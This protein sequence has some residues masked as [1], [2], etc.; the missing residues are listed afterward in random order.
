MFFSFTINKICLYIFHGLSPSPM[1][2]MKCRPH[3]CGEVHE[4]DFIHRSF[5]KNVEPRHNNFK[6]L[7]EVKNLA[8]ETPDRSRYPSCIFPILP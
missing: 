1:V 8:I 3:Y 4:N 6:E 2:E 7:L 5:S